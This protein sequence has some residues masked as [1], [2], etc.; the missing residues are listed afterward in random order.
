[1]LGPQ[2]FILLSSPL[3]LLVQATIKEEMEPFPNIS[4]TESRDL[5]DL[6]SKILTWQPEDRLSLID[7][8]NHPWLTASVRA[9]SKHHLRRGAGRDIDHSCLAKYNF[10]V[11]SRV[12]N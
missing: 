3:R 10:L 11:M 4:E 12:D 2:A 8:K 5:A 1:M 9:S 6:L 7:I